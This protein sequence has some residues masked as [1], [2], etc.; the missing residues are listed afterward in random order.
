MFRACSFILFLFFAA[1]AHSYTFFPDFW[2]LFL[3]FVVFHVYQV[4]SIVVFGWLL[5]SRVSI[6]DLWNKSLLFFTYNFWPSHLSSRCP[7]LQTI[8]FAWWLPC[9]GFW[10]VFNSAC[11]FAWMVVLLL[12]LW[13]PFWYVDVASRDLKKV[14]FSNNNEC[15]KI[16]IKIICSPV[17]LVSYSKCDG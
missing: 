15:T 13:M 17:I 7:L 2:S 12:L 10:P 3:T 4:P 14:I 8:L 5:Y 11:I 16:E 9:P 1:F 6:Q